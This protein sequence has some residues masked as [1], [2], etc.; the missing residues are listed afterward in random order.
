MKM[1]ITQTSLC[2]FAYSERD[3]NLGTT[4]NVQISTLFFPVESEP[5]TSHVQASY[6]YSSNLVE[7]VPGI[8]F[9]KL[10]E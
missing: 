5:G 9:A 2:N 6:D 4:K 8:N 10:Y 1:C 7:L 3:R